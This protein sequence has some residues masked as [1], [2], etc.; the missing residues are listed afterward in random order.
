MTSCFLLF[1]IFISGCSDPYPPKAVVSINIP[2]EESVKTEVKAYFFKDDIKDLLKN[3]NN[4]FVSLNE[5]FKAI[6]ST[7]KSKN[8]SLNFNNISLSNKNSEAEALMSLIK[9]LQESD[10]NR[11]AVWNEN[12]AKESGPI[13]KDIDQL[14]S[15]LN[16]LK[17]LQV[18]VDEYFKDIRNEKESIQNEINQV[19]SQVQEL[20]KSTIIAVN[21]DIVAK[22]LPVYKL[23]E[24]S[25]IFNSQ[26]YRDYNC[27]TDCNSNKMLSLDKR[28]SNG[29]GNC[30]CLTLPYRELYGL[31]SSKVYLQNFTNY[32]SL[33]EK[34]GEK[35]FN[36]FSKE[37]DTN[38]LYGRLRAITKHEKDAEIIAINKFGDYRNNQNEIKDL[39]YKVNN[40]S[41]ELKRISSDE[42][43]ERFFREYFSRQSQELRT[44]TVKYFDTVVNDIL[45]KTTLTSTIE[46]DKSFDLQN[47]LKDLIIMGEVIEPYSP[48]QQEK[49]FI[50]FYTSLDKKFNEKDL[51]KISK[52]DLDIGPNRVILL[53]NINDSIKNSSSEK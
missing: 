38:T 34:L 26:V 45:Q 52:E 21:A 32:I 24:N 46:F 23:S 27:T 49:I 18:Q 2:Q 37:D 33:I 11:E 1:C 4:E 42:N 8:G 43:K 3:Y 51:L 10:G 40:R 41:E 47:G 13:K 12:I 44:L 16:E 9:K 35:Y 39:E 14:N 22:E 50:G 7:D 6:N 48:L 5:I 29:K 53:K 31:E 19:E 30:Y 15:R 28:S 17:P 25:T 20:F 36:S